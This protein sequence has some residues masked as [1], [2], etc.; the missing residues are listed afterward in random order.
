[1]GAQCM[2]GMPLDG[3]SQPSRNVS[4]PS[5]ENNDVTRRRPKFTATTTSRR[6]QEGSTTSPEVHIIDL[7]SAGILSLAQTGQDRCIL[8]ENLRL[9]G[10]SAENIIQ[11]TIA[12]PLYACANCACGFQSEKQPKDTNSVFTSGWLAQHRK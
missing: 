7:L 12:V 1:M 11:S 9:Y 4:Q 10:S 3:V 6:K 2:S 5:S 8:C